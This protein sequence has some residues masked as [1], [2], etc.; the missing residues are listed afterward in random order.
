MMQL[1]LGRAMMIRKIFSAEFF[2]T[3]IVIWLG[4]F[5]HDSNAHLLTGEFANFP[6]PDVHVVTIVLAVWHFCSGCMLA[7]GAICVWTWW[8][9]H[10]GERGA[11]FAPILIGIFYVIS[12]VATALYTGTP[13]F[14]VFVVL[15][16]LLLAPSLVLRRQP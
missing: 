11:L 3:G 4:A 12:G 14:W 16:G 6:A 15:G 1:S 2:L 5:G 10:K 7:F 9:V 13:F 8:R